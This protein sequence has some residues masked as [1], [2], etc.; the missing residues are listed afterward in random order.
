MNFIF[1]RNPNHLIGIYMA[2]TVNTNI[3]NHDAARSTTANM[4]A[5]T[6]QHTT[7]TNVHLRITTIVYDTLY[8]ITKKKHITFVAEE[9]THTHKKRQKNKHMRIET[10]VSV[11]FHLICDQRVWS[12]ESM[13]IFLH[14]GHINLRCVCYSV[15]IAGSE[16]KS[17]WNKKAR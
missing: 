12:M 2:H 6:T 15:M 7:H 9:R 16:T 13:I 3:R 4:L 17:R 1:R 5:C 10:C 14:T 8:E 11:L